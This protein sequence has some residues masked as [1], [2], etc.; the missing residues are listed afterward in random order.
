MADKGIPDVDGA[1][2]MDGGAADEATSHLPFDVCTLI[3]SYL[4]SHLVPQFLT[5]TYF[6]LLGGKVLC[7]WGSHRQQVQSLRTCNAQGL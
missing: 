2:Q 5:S 4:T 1:E 7:M 6:F 3:F